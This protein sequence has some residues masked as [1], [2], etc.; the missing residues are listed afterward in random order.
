MPELPEVETVRRT[1]NELVLGKTIAA[2]D[3]HWGRIIKQPD[4]VEQFK[5]ALIGQ[6]FQTIERRGKFLLFQL[7]DLVL[8]SHLRMEGRYG[9]YEQGEDLTK[10]THIVFR[11][12]DGSELRYQDVRKFG[13]MHV[14]K[15]VKRAQCHL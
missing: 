5:Q 9:L 4:D 7:D 10:H 6:T 3:V 1:L 8:V 2:I 13:T 12:A 11:F 15:K 14:L